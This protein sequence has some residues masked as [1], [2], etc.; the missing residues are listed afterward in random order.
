VPVNSPHRTPEEVELDRK[1]EALGQL[2]TQLLEREL[3]RATLDAELRAFRVRYVMAVGALWAELDVLRAR[4][5]EAKSRI[6]PWNPE[7][8][9]AAAVARHQAAQSSSALS[10]RISDDTTD[11][12][13]SHDLKRLYRD[14]A[15]LVHPDL[16]SDQNERQR[17]TAVMAEANRAYAEGDEAKLRHLIEL[18]VSS[19]ELVPG[20]GVG[21]ELIRTIRKIH[22]VER[23]LLDIAKELAELTAN[24]VH[25]LKAQVDDAHR[26]GRNL[27]EEMAVDLRRQ[28]AS[29]RTELITV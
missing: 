9:H 22:Q 21:P 4:L 3:E 12:A 18:W 11:F 2:E 5:A 16:S 26:L 13:P 25:V 23:R 17:R 24:D 10:V 15:K 20:E 27:I 29:L 14:L 6:K 1:R 8:A 19:P 7:L 28:I